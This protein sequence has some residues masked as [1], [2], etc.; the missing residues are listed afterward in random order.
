VEHSLVDMRFQECREDQYVC[1]LDVLWHIFGVL[2]AWSHSAHDTFLL[3][4][5]L[6]GKCGRSGI[7]DT[8][9]SVS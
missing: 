5:R 7:A 9:E 4:H 3:A 2:F 1:Y 8:I 6:G